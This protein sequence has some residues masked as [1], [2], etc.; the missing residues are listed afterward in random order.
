MT[1]Q[2]NTENTESLMD[3]TS[4]SDIFLSYNLDKNVR[5][6]DVACGVGIVAE[7]IGEFGYRNVDGLDPSKGYVAV[8]Q[9]RGIY[10]VPNLL[11]TSPVLFI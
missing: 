5:I 9:A 1:Q 6:I 4:L 2:P 3:R 11:H 8:V 7:E 10:K